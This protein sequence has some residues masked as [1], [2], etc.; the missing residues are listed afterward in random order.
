MRRARGSKGQR[1][2]CCCRLLRASCFCCLSRGRSHARAPARPTKTTTSEATTAATRPES[3]RGTSPSPLYRRRCGR[4][5]ERIARD[6]TECLR[7]DKRLH[8]TLQASPGPKHRAE[9]PVYSRP[10]CLSAAA[11]QR[12]TKISEDKSKTTCKMYEQLY[13]I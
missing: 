7:H 9:A 12:K 6:V 3:R 2:A 1:S 11:Q 10:V 8:I 5:R 4:L 13:V